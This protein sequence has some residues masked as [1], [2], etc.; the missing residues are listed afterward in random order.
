MKSRRITARNGVR[1]P[2]SSNPETRLFI[3]GSFVEADGGETFATV[4]PATEK[5]IA[6]MAKGT[7]KDVD[8]AVK[9]ARDAFT[10]G[11]VQDGAAG[12]DGSDVQVRRSD[13]RHMPT[14]SRCS[15]R[16]TWASRS[17]TC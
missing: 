1:V 7:A 3:D 13:R 12:S 10:P 8:R 2:R 17:T 5:I 11:L 15:I 16:S 9:A 14:S 6:Q 4:N